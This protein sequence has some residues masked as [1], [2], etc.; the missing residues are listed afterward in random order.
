MYA[1]ATVKLRVSKISYYKNQILRLRYILSIFLIFGKSEAAILI[2]FILLKQAWNPLLLENDCLFLKLLKFFI[3][4]QLTEWRVNTF[5]TKEPET[6]AWIDK[7]KNDKKFREEKIRFILLDEI[8][9][10]RISEDI[11]FDQIKE[12]LSVL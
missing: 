9:K 11:T 12:S 10:S 3:P 2:G 8:G 4:N 6:I 1:F 5:F 7:F